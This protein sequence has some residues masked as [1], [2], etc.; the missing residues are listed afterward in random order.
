[1]HPPHGVRIA[2]AIVT[3]TIARGN[4]IYFH[5]EGSSQVSSNL[6]KFLTLKEPFS[7]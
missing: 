6:K 5:L 3:I 2:T 1:M 7:S 4:H